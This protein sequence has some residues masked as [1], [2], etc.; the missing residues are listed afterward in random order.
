[1]DISGDIFETPFQEDFVTSV[2]GKRALVF[3]ILCL[4]K[5]G[6]LK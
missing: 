1:M 3:T 2:A 5:R 4:L 6:C